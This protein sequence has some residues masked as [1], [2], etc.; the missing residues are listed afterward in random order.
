MSH[1]VRE[2]NTE[3]IETAEIDKSPKN[4][5]ENSPENSPDN[6]PDNNQRLLG[7]VSSDRFG[8]GNMGGV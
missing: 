3:N 7:P 6:N 5:P 4:N 2:G 1:Q 8:Y